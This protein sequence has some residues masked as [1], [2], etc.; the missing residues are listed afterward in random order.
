MGLFPDW[1]ACA[2][3]PWQQRQRDQSLQ[4]LESPSTWGGLRSAGVEGESGNPCLIEFIV[5]PWTF[6]TGC[7]GLWGLVDFSDCLFC[8]LQHLGILPFLLELLCPVGEKKQTSG[9]ARS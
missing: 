2:A 3:A 6:Y 8:F 5:K 7:S 1:P 4:R 9:N